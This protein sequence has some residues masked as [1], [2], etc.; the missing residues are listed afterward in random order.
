MNDFNRRFELSANNSNKNVNIDNPENIK[1]VLEIENKINEVK[2]TEEVKMDVV[3]EEKLLGKKRERENNYL[4][5]SLSANGN[6]F[7]RWKET[8][9]GGN[10]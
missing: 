5:K 6:V 3:I 8:Q 2:N 4:E 9:K 7:N 10:K 1:D